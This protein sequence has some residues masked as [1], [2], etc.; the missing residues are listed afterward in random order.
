MLGL[1]VHAIKDYFTACWVGMD[2]EMG[3]IFVG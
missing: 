3:K 2:Q 1:G